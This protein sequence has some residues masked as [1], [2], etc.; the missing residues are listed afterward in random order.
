MRDADEAELI[1]YPVFATGTTPRTARGRTQ[2]HAWSVP[3]SLG[4]VTVSPGD[5]VIADGTGV[6]VVPAGDIGPV[7]LA[8]ESIAAKESLMAIAIEQGQPIT[9]VMGAHYETM[10]HGRPA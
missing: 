2:E 7:L 4:T 10:L 8:A 6:V 5:Y 1:A 9:T 3:V